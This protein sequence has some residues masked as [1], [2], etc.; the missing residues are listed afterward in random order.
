MIA[1][2]LEITSSVFDDGHEISVFIDENVISAGFEH[3]F[4]AARAELDAVFTV[5]KVFDDGVAGAAL[6]E[7]GVASCLP[8][9]AVFASTTDEEIVAT[10]A[11]EAI[12]AGLSVESVGSPLPM[13]MSLPEPARTFSMEIRRSLPSPVFCQ[14]VVLRLMRLERVE[15]WS[16]VGI[17]AAVEGVVARMSEEGVIEVSADHQIATTVPQK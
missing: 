8:P 15:N 4:A 11:I 6:N 3:E 14:L 17:R 1:V 7:E 10:S 5:G 12:T 9:D 16:G 13:T 2:V